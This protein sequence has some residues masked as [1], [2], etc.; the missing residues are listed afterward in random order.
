[1]NKKILALALATV[2]LGGCKE[3]GEDTEDISLPESAITSATQSAES[4]PQITASSIQSSKASAAGTT[5]TSV[6]IVKSAPESAVTQDD[7]VFVDYK[8]TENYEGIIDESLVAERSAKAK[9]ALK[10]IDEYKNSSA[11]ISFERA[12][13]EDFD[14]DGKDD[15]I[16]VLSTL[17]DQGSNNIELFLV[18]EN[19]TEHIV[20]IYALREKASFDLLD[21]GCCKQLLFYSFSDNNTM[22]VCRIID[23]EDGKAAA[24]GEVWQCEGA[25][26]YGPFLTFETGFRQSPVYGFFDAKTKRYYSSEGKRLTAEELAALDKT[27]SLKNFPE[28]NSAVY[29][30]LGGMYYTLTVPNGNLHQDFTVLTCENGAFTEVE[31][32]AIRQSG[33]EFAPIPNLDYEKAMNSA[34]S[35][36]EAKAYS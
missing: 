10:A 8:L 18:T 26:K 34:I 11:E 22:R 27:D 24:L 6:P 23:V 21:Y 9:E 19:G 33:G 30:H 14:G 15:T 12:F 2:L 25:A 3:G 28:T 20:T 5:K 17:N 36:E 1:M 4:S 29:R 16:A 31:N 13:V 32:T 7:I 35:V